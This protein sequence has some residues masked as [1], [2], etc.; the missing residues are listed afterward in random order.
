MKESSRRLWGIVNAEQHERAAALEALERWVPHGRRVVT[1]GSDTV[2]SEDGEPLVR[3]ENVVE[4][5]W[6]AT[7]AATLLLGFLKVFRQDPSA[8]IVTVLRPD[9]LLS[10]RGFGRLLRRARAVARG[11]DNRLVALARPR[12]AAPVRSSGLVPIAEH[13]DATLAML[14]LTEQDAGMSVPF[15]FAS[16]MVGNTSAFLRLYETAHPSLLRAMLS[17]AETRPSIDA[18][19][20]GFQMA[21]DPDLLSRANGAIK[22]LVAPLAA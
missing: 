11:C 19:D 16:V 15:Q 14:F 13:D 1:V 4:S 9:P 18:T 22:T 3:P 17:R 2:G 10:H 12:D 5:R 20:R 7:S 21:V 8:Q 6:A